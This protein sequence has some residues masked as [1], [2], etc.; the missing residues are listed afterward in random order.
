MRF[1]T[2]ELD[3]RYFSP[4]EPFQHPD[5]MEVEIG[6]WH[7]KFWGQNPPAEFLEAE[8]RAQV[9]WIL[10]L[11]RMAPSLALEGPTV[12]P[13]GEG[14]FRIQVSVRNQGFLPTSLT[15]R[16]AVGVEGSDGEVRAQVVPPPF[17]HLGSRGVELIEG[18]A[19]VSLPHLSGQGPYLADIGAGEQR[20]EW[21]VRLAEDEGF[22]MATARSAKAGVARSGWVRV[23]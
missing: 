14:R 9:P 5:G 11:L 12:T 20:V 4:W 13:L 19:R 17:V 15:G 3:G 8:C 22:V 10:H 1:N 16:G 6:G 2:E 7:Q 18:P 21:I 23:R